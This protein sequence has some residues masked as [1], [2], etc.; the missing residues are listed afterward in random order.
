MTSSGLS[1]DGEE[2][3]LTNG[4]GGN[5]GDGEGFKF[6]WWMVIVLV[7]VLVVIAGAGIAM[8]SGGDK[9]AEVEFG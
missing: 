3:D 2:S 9:F 8:M 1:P 5:S 6:E 7:V 4:K